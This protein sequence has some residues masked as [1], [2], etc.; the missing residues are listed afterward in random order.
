MAPVLLQAFDACESGPMIWSG[1][2]ITIPVVHVPPSPAETL[3]V[4]PELACETQEA[5]EARSGVE[6]QVG[7]DP[8]HA[9]H[10]DWAKKSKI[11]I[12]GK[13]LTI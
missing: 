9:A 1:L 12:R 4:S 13:I 8:L 3:I 10:A 11:Q 6:L 7:V 5:I 2:S